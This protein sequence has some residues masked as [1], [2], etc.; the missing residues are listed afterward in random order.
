MADPARVGVLTFHRCINYGSYWQARCLVEGLRARGLEA[1]LLDH[2][3]RRADRAEW[4]CALRPHLPEP[5]DPADRPPYARK[6][7]RFAEAFERTLPLSAPFP[8]EAPEA[9]GTWDAVVVGSDEVWNLRHPWYAGRRLFFG[10]GLRA[11]RLIS[12]AASVGNHDAADGLSPPWTDYLRRFDSLSVRDENSRRLIR[13]AVGVDP[14]VVLDPCLQFPEPLARPVGGSDEVVVYGHGF[15]AWFAAR[16]RRWARGRSLRLVSFGYR[17][18][19]CDAS[20]LD[21]GPEVFAEVMTS[22]RAVVTNFFHGCVF[23]LLHRR[24]F[25]CALSAYR[26]N[27]VRDL[28][29][30]LGAEAHLMTETSDDPAYAR[31]LDQPPDATVQ[32]RLGQARASSSN[33]LDKALAGS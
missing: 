7:R 9:A 20:R 24:P 14:V 8:L 15:P 17:N 22:A 25:A 10:D 12:Y 2:R 18:A 13:G 3:S 30:R 31:A 1:V 26:T 29:E 23:S 4:S 5:T 16:V 21:E 11:D 6:V 19:W 27:K 32:A 28:A 33:F